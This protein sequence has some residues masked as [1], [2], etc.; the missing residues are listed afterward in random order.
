MEPMGTRRKRRNL[1][2]VFSGTPGKYFFMR[3]G[4]SLLCLT[5]LFIAPALCYRQRWLCRRTSITG[6]PL[7]FNG[8][9]GDLFKNLI[10]WGFFSLITLGIYGVFFAP[11]RYKQWV[12]AHTC[13]G[14]I[15][16]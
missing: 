12:A 2:S 6:V 8:T 3:L 4:T 16:I 7:E 1:R 9:G 13:F 10:K 14:P 5:V 15:V 11:L